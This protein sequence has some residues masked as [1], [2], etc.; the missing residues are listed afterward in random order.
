MQPSPDAADEDDATAPPP[1]VV[2]TPAQARRIALG[3]QGFAGA[4]ARGRVNAASSHADRPARPAADRLRQ[5]ALPRPLP[6]AVLAARR[7]SDRD[8]AGAARLGRE[9]P[10]PVR[11]LGARGLAAAARP[12]AAV[13]LAHGAGRARPGH[14]GGHRRASAASGAPS[15][16]RCWRE[17]ET[18]G[19]TRRRATSTTAASG[20]GGW[21]GWSD[22]KR[23][24]ECLFWAGRAHHRHPARQLRA[25][26][27]PARA[28]P[29]RAESWPRRR[30]HDEDAQRE[31]LRS[32]PAR[33]ASP[34]SATCATISAWRRRRRS[35]A[36]PS[37]SRPAN[38]SR[39]RSR[40]GASRPI[41]RR[42]AP[43][44]AQGRGARPALAVR[45]AD[46]GAR[47]APSAC[48]ASA[49]ASRSTRPPHKREHGY[50][51]LPFLLGDRIVARVDLKADR[52]TNGWW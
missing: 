49:T 32:P 19:P 25:G 35:R 51:V 38:S 44:P 24:L 26:L 20:E 4:A 14:L 13:A 23:A 52:F 6:A 1:A 11:I 2:L 5:R 9:A 18:R 8:A 36:S 33:W 50:Y 21:W 34:P 12:P 30:P 16:T 3:A 42:D 10:P 47:R 39:S 46:L 22:G 7:L 48:S 28:R 15:S 37:W 45:S 17:I 41:S 27:R 29:A 31:L 43:A 40:A